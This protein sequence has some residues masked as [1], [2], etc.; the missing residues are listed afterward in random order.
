MSL[1]TKRDLG[2]T[3]TQLTPPRSRSYGTTTI[4]ADTALRSSAVWACCRLRADL[5]STLPLNTYRMVGKMQVEAGRP[6]F[7]DDPAADGF[8]IEDWL[9]SSQVDLDR[10]GNAFG[11]IVARDA[12]GN[13]AVVEL[14][15]LARVSIVG[16]GPQITG[17]RI[18]GK[19]Y[20][21]RDVWHERQFTI[22]GVPLGLSPIAYAAMSIGGYLSA[23][24]FGLDWFGNGTI[25]SGRL[26]NTARTVNPTEAA[27]IKDRYKAAVASRDIF[28]H[29]T[30]W[31]FN[32]E[33]VTANES[34][35][36]ETMQYG[37][38]DIAR[39]F[40]VPGDMIDAPAESSA[41]ITYANI[42]QRNLQFLVMN[43]G[44]TIT[45]RER[46]LSRAIVRPRFVKF[47]TEAFLRLD[48]QTL[49][50]MLGGQITSR[51]LAPSEARAISNRMPFTADQIEE[52]NV[53]FGKSQPA[54]GMSQGVT[55]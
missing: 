30:D 3:S 14:S 12:L 39:F 11:L 36:L 29:G 15:P 48:P 8:G 19:P 18:G 17:Y 45:R 7:L 1:F 23:Q 40:G 25:P 10:S 51:Q 34:Q 16:N 32:A 53:L 33:Q 52:F 50:T 6:A 44:P 20:E 43:L 35:F 54:P 31:E 13:P 38:Q 2:D 46:A 21:P 37:I 5:L 27:V 55:P 42:T 49:A 22:P 26:K 47:D 9:Y 24:Q 28:V 4:S 41:K